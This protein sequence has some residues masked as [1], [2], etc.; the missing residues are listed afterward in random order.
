MTENPT[1]STSPGIPQLPSN[2]TSTQPLDDAGGEIRC[3]CEYNEDDGYTVCCDKCGTWQH[4]ACMQLE[5]DIPS[6]YLCNTCSPRPV[7][8]KRAKELQK[9]RRRDEKVNRRKRSATTAHKKKDVHQSSGHHGQNGATVGKTIQG[10]EKTAIVK[11]P[12]PR[13]PQA[14]VAPVSRK[15]NQRVSHSAGNG[16]VAGSTS[17][18]PDR[19]ADAES[20]TDL[21]KYRYE[22]ID[23]GAGQNR[24]T[25][26]A[27]K[28]F[29]SNALRSGRNDEHV[30]RYSQHDFAA[31]PF[32]KASV[33]AVPDPSKSYSELPR[34]CYVLEASCSRGKPVALFKGELGFQS[35][36]KEETINQYA[37]WHHPKPHVIFHPALPVYVD[38]RRHGSEAR[39]VRRS[40]KPNLSIKI[41]LVDDSSVYVGLFAAESIKS[42]TELTLGWDWSGLEQSQHLLDAG[43]EFSKVPADEMKLAALWVDNLLDKM[44]D[45]ACA[46]RN[47]CLLA[48]IKECGGVDTAVPKRPA[49][50]GIGNGNSKKQRIKR[51]PSTESSRSK[52]PTPDVQQGNSKDGDPDRKIKP[53]SRDP[54]PVHQHEIAVDS[55]N[56]T[57]RE[58]RKFKEVLSRIEKQEEQVHQPSKRRKRNSAT[59]DLTTGGDGAVARSASPGSGDVWGGV[60]ERK[61]KPHTGDSPV[62]S[63][64][65]VGREVSVVDAGSGR[66]PGSSTGSIGHKRRNTAGSSPAP[67]A[68]GSTKV[69]RK[70]KTKPVRLNYV[71][72]SAQTETDD[73]LPWWKLAV[74]MTPPRPPRLPLRKRLMQ[75]LLK[76]REEA[77]SASTSASTA[78]ASGDDKKRKHDCFAADTAV[79]LPAPKVQKT[80]E[81]EVTRQAVG[82]LVVPPAAPVLGPIAAV[83]T[84]PT[85]APELPD[86][87][88][89]VV[90]GAKSPRHVVPSPAP[91]SD[92]TKS[93]RL[94]TKP[95]RLPSPNGLSPTDKYRVNNGAKP[96][97]LHLELPKP[98]RV[99]ASPLPSTQGGVVAQP[100]LTISTAVPFSPSVMA[101]VNSATSVSSPS[102]TK[103]KK[104]SL[105][106]YYNR[107]H[108]SVDL[109]AERK[110]DEAISTSTP[111]GSLATADSTQQLA[112]LNVITPSDATVPP[113]ATPVEA[114]IV[115]GSTWGLR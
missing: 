74:P 78:I 36:Y 111:K 88:P 92:S 41:M 43:F 86:A 103:T 90:E 109:T 114:K 81:K 42:G 60:E 101:A 63:P 108:K 58:E 32:P 17:P 14:P 24:Y 104:L 37:L 9:Q 85:A 50:N 82:V 70:V 107:S 115:P 51:N 102:P 16:S 95:P 99:A 7:E 11:L 30:K 5:D 98:S 72:S 38:A 34:W 112:F 49:T 8:A 75:S 91:V 44:G 113:Q 56:M 66:S 84:A 33:R 19:N 29:L 40:C 61:T 45:C 3:I 59:S 55:A 52:E 68:A 65:S 97:G 47:E 46:D 73:E 20:D 67:S 13:E 94:R 26:D 69:R 23:I 77:V 80:V 35:E 64:R 28:D 76:D 87:P 22:F 54:T 6:N 15:R 71:D 105:K 79:S 110:E 12:S 1:A 83:A 96:A 39:F 27:V 48:K 21:D 89:I 100:P 106:E 93:E 31:T 4:V 62:T 10:S 57:R 25:S 18:F 53:S 2:A